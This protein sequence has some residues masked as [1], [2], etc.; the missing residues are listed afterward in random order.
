VPDE[1]VEVSGD[2]QALLG[3]G[4][5]AD[6]LDAS[7]LA[8]H[9]HCGKQHQHGDGDEEGRRA[10]A[11]TRQVGGDDEEADRHSGHR[12]T[13]DRP[14][15][16]VATDG[17]RPDQ[18]PRGVRRNWAL[19]QGQGGVAGQD[20]P[21]HQ[22]RIA[23]PCKQGKAGAQGKEYRGDALDPT[24]WIGIRPAGLH[25]SEV[26]EDDEDRQDPVP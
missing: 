20:D 3:G 4:A 7:A 6:G 2:A 26:G 25:R 21:G 23:A 12:R 1:V 17:E 19:D 5:P 9:Q 8:A 11:G 15:A 16:V 22:A 24:R 14:T 13:Y 18:D 10:V